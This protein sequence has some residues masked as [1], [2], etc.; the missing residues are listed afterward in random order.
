M[1]QEARNFYDAPVPGIFQADTTGDEPVP[2]TVHIDTVPRIGSRHTEGKGFTV[3]ESR[4]RRPIPSIG[5]QS[6]VSEADTQFRRGIPISTDATDGK[7]RYPA[8]VDDTR[9]SLYWSPGIGGPHPA[10]EK[11]SNANPILYTVK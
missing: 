7:K 6:P 9:Y 4:Y 1:E 11:G 3:S 2:G 8:S 10:S 5:K